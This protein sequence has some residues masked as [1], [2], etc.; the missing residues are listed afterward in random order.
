MRS[1]VGIAH[2]WG[3]VFSFPRTLLFPV[4]PENILTLHQSVGWI[5]PYLVTSASGSITNAD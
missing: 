5:G 4:Y 2:V 3:T 1:T